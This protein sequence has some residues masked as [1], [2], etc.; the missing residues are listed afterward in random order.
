MPALRGEDRFPLGTAAEEAVE[1]MTLTLHLHPRMRMTSS[2]TDGT[3]AKKLATRTQ[4]MT[5]PPEMIEPLSEVEG[6]GVGEGAITTK[7][8]PEADL[9]EDP[10]YKT[11][12]VRAAKEQSASP[13][14][15][16]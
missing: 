4:P 11:S 9:G 3:K 15:S 8:L 12:T 2:H 13:S 6:E 7:P 1:M 14:G 5:K 16:C 10:H